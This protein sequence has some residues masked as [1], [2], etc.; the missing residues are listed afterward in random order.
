MKPLAEK[1]A[2][3]RPYG[4]RTAFGF[5]MAS[6]MA[7][8]L[9]AWPSVYLT[10][11]KRRL[12]HARHRIVESDHR[13]VI[14]AFPR[15]GSSFTHRAFTAA[16]P[17][18]GQLVATHMHRASQ[19]IQ[20]SRLGVPTLIIVR[21]PRDA[22]TSLLALGIEQARL[23]VLARGE[24]ELCLGI[25]LLRYA[26]FH[27]RIACVPGVT[28]AGFDEV[29][30]N[31]GTV[32]KRVNAAFGTNFM[33]FEHTDATANDLMKKSKPHVSPNVDRD[34]IKAILAAAYDSPALLGK[35]TRADKAYEVMIARRDRQWEEGK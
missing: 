23:P 31:M 4:K 33:P 1:L 11:Q 30:R 8:L 10:L 32:I 5:I 15:S 12:R 35:R 28:V 25:T 19:V 7:D 22:V 27:E 26:R 34:E 18:D 20:A 29:T 14:E 9:D 2:M 16:N 24:A 21:V 6:L 3:F 13:F 17:Q